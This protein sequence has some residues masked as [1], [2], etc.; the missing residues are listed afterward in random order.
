MG[1]DQVREPDRP[2]GLEQ[3]CPQADA[4]AEQH[5]GAPGDPRLG[6]GPGH[7]A[8]AR[9]KHQGDSSDRRRGCVKAMQDTFGGQERD[10]GKRKGQ[11]L[12]LRRLHR[13]QRRESLVDRLTTS[14]NRVDLGSHHPRHHE[15]KRH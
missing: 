14:G 10:K 12:L 9:Q 8:H 1:D 5:D 4:D 13:P 2:S 11:Q 7:D 15:V 6:L 3:R